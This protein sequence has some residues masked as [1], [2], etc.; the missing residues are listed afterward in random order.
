MLLMPRMLKKVIKIYQPNAS[1][2]NAVLTL[3]GPS[4]FKPADI[5]A[6]MTAS[7]RVKAFDTV[8]IGERLRN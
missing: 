7:S 5:T 2:R 6:A 8:R 1:V 4:S 3:S